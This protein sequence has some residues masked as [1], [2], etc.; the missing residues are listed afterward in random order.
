MKRFVPHIAIALVGIVCLAV[1]WHLEPPITML[2]KT[3]PPQLADN[4]AAREFFVRLESNRPL[5]L[6]ELRVTIAWDRSRL[7]APRVWHANQTRAY[8]P[9]TEIKPGQM[10]LTFQNPRRPESRIVGPGRLARLAFRLADRRR[11]LDLGALR[12]VSAD[13]LTADGRRVPVRDLSFVRYEPRAKH[14]RGGPSLPPGGEI[15][16]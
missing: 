5:E 6:T 13:G 8:R 3:P 15:E 7:V 12:I 1:I 16:I 9:R 4:A 14:R 2:K 10:T 11:P